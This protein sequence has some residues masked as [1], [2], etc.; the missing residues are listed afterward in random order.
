MKWLGIFQVGIFWVGIFR[1]VIFQGGVDGM[2]FS[3]WEF[4]REGIFPEPF[5][6]C[7]VSANIFL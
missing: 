4:S 5:L 6:S 3:E 1:G 2:E 7:Y